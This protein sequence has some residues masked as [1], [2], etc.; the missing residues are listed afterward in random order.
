[1]IT[2][3]IGVQNFSSVHC[4]IIM[5]F[6]TMDA[7]REY[8]NYN[9][10]F[11]DQLINICGFY[12]NS[13]Y[14]CDRCADSANNLDSTK[15]HALDCP[16][17]QLLSPETQLG[18][19]MPPDP[20]FLFRSVTSNMLC[21]DDIAEMYNAALADPILTTGRKWTLPIAHMST[22]KKVT[23]NNRYLL[24]E[25]RSNQT[26]PYFLSGQRAMRLLR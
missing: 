16:Y 25:F 24:A 13:I 11:V 26:V 20:Y 3:L 7:F 19:M 8:I 5:F 6:M 4:Y 9:Y 15:T 12:P 14:T 17:F 10:I 22:F 21:E 2:K 1:M 18:N 23:K